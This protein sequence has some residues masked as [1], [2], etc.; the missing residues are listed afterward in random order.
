MPHYNTGFSSLQGCDGDANVGLGRIFNQLT[1][2]RSLEGISPLLMRFFRGIRANRKWR[3]KSSVNSN[4]KTI[5]I[6]F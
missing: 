3:V 6:I 4:L 5:E 2:N 1:M